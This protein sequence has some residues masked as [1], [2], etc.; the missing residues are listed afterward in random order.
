[1][2]DE[3]IRKIPAGR[4]GRPE[5]IAELA[6]FLLSPAAA[7]I[8]GEVI[9]LDGGESIRRGGSFNDLVDLPAE[10]W[11]ELRSRAKR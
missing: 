3:L 5:E 2:V 1:M 4:L 10:R 8:C 9:T 7:W 11:Q 6:A